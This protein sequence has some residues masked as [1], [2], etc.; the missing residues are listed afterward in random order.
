MNLKNSAGTF[1]DHLNE[2]RSRVLKSGAAIFIGVCIAYFFRREIFR[3]LRFPF[4]TAYQHVYGVTPKLIYLSMLEGFMVYLK[5]SV[6]AGFFLA[7]PVVFYQL[8]QFIGPGLKSNEK[9]HV[10]PFVFLATLF[11]VGGALFGY[12]LVFPEG[13]EFFLSITK[14]ENIEATIQMDQYYQFASW[15]LLGFGVSFEGPLILLYLVYL[16]ILN[17][18]HL[19]R[20]WREATV[21]ILVLSAVITPTPDMG[22]MMLMAIPLIAMYWFTVLFSIIIAKK[23]TTDVVK[24]EK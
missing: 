17:T 21:A 5:M 7:S 16:R 12:F 2:L 10:L 1:W 24:Y 20:A 19:M 23:K 15:M 18:R 22:T 13:F 4:D 6:L 3:A 14:G 11:F 8:W 9:K